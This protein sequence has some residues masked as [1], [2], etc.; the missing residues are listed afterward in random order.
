MKKFW[1][2]YRKEPTF[3]P[4]GG[5]EKEVDF[6]AVYDPNDGTVLVNPSIYQF[7]SMQWA[8][9]IA[10]VWHT[11]QGEIWSPMGEARSLI[12]AL[13]LEHTSMSVGDLIVDEEGSVF[14]VDRIGFKEILV[15]G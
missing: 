7:V 9:E 6:Q 11:M 4:Y 15:R 10:D 13:G 5:F 14:E 8:D 1:V 12:K 3:R 2:Y